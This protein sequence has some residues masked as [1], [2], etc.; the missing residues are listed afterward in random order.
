MRRR[1]SIGV[2]LAALICAVVLAGCGGSA[3]SAAG[4]SADKAAASESETK[5][6]EG[7]RKMTIRIQVGTEHFTARVEDNASVRAL[8]E[9]LP[10][11]VDMSELN[12]NE[13]YYNLQEQLPAKEEQVGSIR[14]GDLMLFGSDCLVLF[15]K[16]FQTSYSYT[17]LGRIEDVL[18]LEKALGDG[19]VKVTFSPDN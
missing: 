17:R 19:S 12:G 2:L 9:L 7:D 18:G 11:T 15:Y 8:E 1:R 6:T 5:Q 4:S 14:A 16:D 3:D 10:L 13:K